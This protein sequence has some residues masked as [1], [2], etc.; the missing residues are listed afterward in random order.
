V[1]IRKQLRAYAV[2]AVA[3]VT[4]SL[5]T[6]LAPAASAAAGGD[7]ASLA[8]AN[9]GKT[10][11]TCADDPTTNSLGGSQFETSC[12]GNGGQGE[13]WCA[14]FAEW[15]WE[16]SGFS[17]GGLSAAAGSFYVYGENNGTLHTSASYQP[18]PGDAVV[19]DYAGGGVA[20]HVGIVTSVASN[21]DV[22]TANGD[23]GGISGSSQAVYARSSSVVSV[24]IPASES[25]TGDYVGPA[26][27]TISGYIT[28]VAGGTSGAPVESANPYSPSSVCGSGYG[29]VDSHGI[30]GATIY[31]LYD[32]A[33]GANCVVTLAGTPTSAKSMNATLAVQNGSS[34]SSPG[35]YTYYA[36]PVTEAAPRSC[37]Q[38][39]GSYDGSSWTSGWSH[40][41][42][43][44]SAPAPTGDNIYTPTQVCGSGYGVIDSHAVSGATIYLLHNGSTGDDCVTTLATNA[45]AAKP[46]NATLS[47]Q[48]GA[49]ASDPGTSTYY[50][51]PVTAHAPNS[52]VQWGG[53]YDGST[54]TS[55]WSHC[56]NGTVTAPRGAGNPYTPTQ[57]CGAGYRIVDSHTVGGATV[58]LLYN[59]S[60]GD[61]C[62]AMMSDDPSSAASMNATLSV[63]GG[64]SASDPGT[65]TYYAG[66]VTE[67]APASCVEWGGSYANSSWTSGWS[68]C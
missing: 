14:D 40:C 57:V 53:S 15:V 1:T 51:G 8:L 64:A 62:T 24:T 49:T 50:A 17:T 7:A 59:S 30:T 34:A 12:S 36:G 56:G 39:G 60:S 65:S 11:G 52:C 27:M 46:M 68:H 37:V 9:I 38:W 25:A 3:A 54:W 18:K 32:D 6:A 41:G 33:T 2:A 10:A 19:Y 28:P 21:G 20:D 35:T 44:S 13:Y 42:G 45:S 26:E 47:L 66:P 29:V 23:W 31:L 67:H 16:N 58:Y 22:V 61:T 63:R 5:A 48:D 43:G 55:S 4:L